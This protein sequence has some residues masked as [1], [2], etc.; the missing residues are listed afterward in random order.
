MRILVPDHP[1]ADN[2]YVFEHR[3]IM[4][5][6]LRRYLRHDEVVHHLNGN[7]SDNRIENLELMTNVQ[8]IRMHSE[9]RRDPITGQF[10]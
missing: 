1:F 8:H 4:E 3:Y 6:H 9:S 2:G 7:K 10:V 5:K